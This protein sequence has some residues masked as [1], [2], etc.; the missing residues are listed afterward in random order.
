M[1]KIPSVKD[2]LEKAKETD[3]H[4]V[5]TFKAENK[6]RRMGYR[7]Y[8]Y[9]ELPYEVKQKLGGAPDVCAEKEGNWVF[10]EV[11]VT[12]RV[13]IGNYLKAGKVILVLP[14]ESARNAEVWGR[15]ELEK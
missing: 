2:V 14:I 6:L 15:E 5:L 3:P 12:G 10:V 8:S 1:R 4:T 11:T 7:I 13:H 9:D